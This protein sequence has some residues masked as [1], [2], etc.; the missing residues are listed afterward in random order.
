MPSLLVNKI[1]LLRLGPGE[2]H[3]LKLNVN[4]PVLLYRSQLGRPNLAPDAFWTP[5]ACDQP[6]HFEICTLHP[7]SI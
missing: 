3:T 6:S 5:N 2:V 7:H 4:H 1:V